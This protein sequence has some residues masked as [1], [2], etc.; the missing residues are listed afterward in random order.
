MTDM[1]THMFMRITIHPS[2]TILI[3]ITIIITIHPIILYVAYDKH[4]VV[5][6]LSNHPQHEAH[7]SRMAPCSIAAAVNLQD[8]LQKPKQNGDLDDIES[9]AEAL[10]RAFPDQLAVDLA[11][12]EK[13]LAGIHDD[14][15][16]DMQHWT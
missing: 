13:D 8:W 5:L 12:I 11:N 1:F 4:T 2:S 10:A 9:I 15:S 6:M 14:S 16:Q 3:T 7:C